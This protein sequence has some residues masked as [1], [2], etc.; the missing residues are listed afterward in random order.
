MSL[1]DAI[2]PI[3][4]LLGVLVFVHELGHFVVAK[5]F[6]VRVERFSLGFGPALL[7]RRVGETE[8]VIAA[9]PLGGYV[10]MLG[11]IPG[12]E[13][14]E[15]DRARAFNYKPPWQ[16][17]AIAL[18]GPAMNVVLPVF[19]V[20]ALLMAGIPTLT[21]SVGA[22]RPGTPAE[23]AGLLPGDRITSVS[24]SE[25]WRW[26]DLTEA[27]RLRSTPEVE[28]G[29][30][31]GGEQLSFAVARERLED[32]S[33]GP[34]GVEPFAASSMVGVADEDGPAAVAGIQSGDVITEVNGTPVADRY[35]LEVALAAARGEL[36]LELR[37]KLGDTEERLIIRVRGDA[38]PRSLEGLGL[39]LADFSVIDVQPVSPAR[40]AGLQD[41][42]LFLR[43]A[44]E[45][46]S[47]GNQVRERIRASEGRPIEVELL[48]AGERVTVE[49][50]ATRRLIP[51]G[52]GMETHFV[53]GISIGPELTGGTYA[54]EVVSNP[55]VALWRGVDRTFEMLRLIIVGVAQLVTGSVG[56][57][58]LAGP[59]GIGE[60]AADTLQ[61]SWTDFFSFMA[62]ISVN[63]A[64]LNLLPIPVLDGGQILLTLAEMARGS[65]LPDRAREMA[66]AMGFSLILVLMGF[67]FWNDIS[68]NWEGIIGFLKSLV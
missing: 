6:D 48:R 9:L 13:L 3:V 5:L 57:E 21:S 43:V 30:E 28:I 23:L 2:L 1:G 14:P 17:I 24:G 20:A 39:V 61:R 22:V 31:R 34:I 60:I 45:P 26:K 18:A 25:I 35:A 62:V 16:R 40:A 33:L 10:K 50:S 54:D 19:M 38:A 32:G 7:R 68:R 42:D 36:E 37:R 49:L 51:A 65:P 4:I 46:V 64:I 63:L 27:L 53:I 52:D 12:E 59:I 66:Q 41:G 55:L 11:E 44:G 56:V 8:Y 58:S 67:A 47:S 15:P 29:V